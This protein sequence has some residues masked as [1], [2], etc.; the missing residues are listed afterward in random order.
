MLRLTPWRRTLAVFSTPTVTLPSLDDYTHARLISQVLTLYYVEEKNQS[1][2]AK[3]LGLSTAKVNRLIKQARAHGMVEIHLRPPF[4]EL[5]E[6]ERQVEAVCG[7]PEAVVIPQVSADA[8]VAMQTIGP[9][10]ADYLLQHVRDGDVICISGGK[11]LY[12]IIHALNPKKRYDVTVVP[13]TGGY[14]GRHYNDVNYLAGELAARLGGKAYQLHAPVLVDTTEEREALLS[15]RQIS[16]ILDL[17]RQARIA[18]VGVGSVVTRS[19]SY[20]ELPFLSASDK[21]KILEECDSSGE[22]LAYLYDSRGHLCAQPFNQ[23]VIGI[24]PQELRA[25]PLR[26]G[27][28]ASPEKELPIY[29]ALQGEYLTT[30]VTDEPTARGVLGRYER[31]SN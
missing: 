11:A 15:V 6:L 9:A 14:Q 19:S 3:I 27:V 20:F 21:K 28:A 10:A 23:R 17:A 5:F 24:T 8:D 12:A 18:I 13:A 26:I 25:I 22:I 2:V 7:I 30:I 31:A 4:Q 1:Q 16:S 29:G